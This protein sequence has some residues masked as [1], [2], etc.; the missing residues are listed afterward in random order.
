MSYRR[1]SHL[2]P[3]VILQHVEV[4]QSNANFMLSGTLHLA[5][6]FINMPIGCRGKADMISSFADFC[7]SKK[8]TIVV[9]ENSDKLC[10]PRTLCLGIAYA[11][12]NINEYRSVRRGV[13]VQRDR[14]VAQCVAA[15]IDVC[16][17]G[18]GVKEM[19][20]FQR[21]LNKYCITVF[22]ARQGKSVIFEGTKTQNNGAMRKHIDLIYGERLFNLMLRITGAFNCVYYCRMCR[23]HYKNAY[24]HRCME[25]CA[26]CNEQPPCAPTD[27]RTC[28][29]C[30]RRRVFQKTFVEEGHC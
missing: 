14:A 1:Y 18:G 5:F 24:V 17:T 2:K 26:I 10:L 20:A 12:S 22:D 6:K 4:E 9:I 3:D 19:E 21:H 11:S 27:L 30:N 25:K 23:F 7:K 29:I 15:G 28:E 8:K 13:R 16:E